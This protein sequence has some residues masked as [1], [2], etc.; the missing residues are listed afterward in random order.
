MILL[1]RSM[2][3]LELLPKLQ[4]N[5]SYILLRSFFQPHIKKRGSLSGSLVLGIC[6]YQC[7]TV[8][9]QLWV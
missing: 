3:M 5:K 8:I 9:L 7:D 6:N 2:Q 4:Q 1:L